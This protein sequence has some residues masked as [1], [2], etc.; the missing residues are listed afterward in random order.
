M[1]KRAVPEAAAGSEPDDDE[2]LGS[3]EEEEEPSAKKVKQG[4]WP[5]WPRGAVLRVRAR[6]ARPG[7]RPAARPAL[8]RTAQVRMQDFMTYTDVTID[9]GARLNLILGPNGTGAAQQA[10]ATPRAPQLTSPAQARARWCA[11]C[12]WASRAPPRRGGGAGPATRGARLKPAPPR[13]SSAA[14][15][16]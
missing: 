2:V 10:R 14:P 9:P 13:S 5:A 1:G 4:E 6:D 16:T 8:T 15:R 11:R 3:D 12:A 7:E